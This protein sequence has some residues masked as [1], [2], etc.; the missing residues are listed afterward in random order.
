M[1][2]VLVR[3]DLHPG[4]EPREVI[5]DMVDEWYYANRAKFRSPDGN[6]ETFPMTFRFVLWEDGQDL[7]TDDPTPVPTPSMYSRTSVVEQRDET[8]D[9]EPNI[10]QVNGCGAEI[11]DDSTVCDHCAALACYWCSEHVPEGNGTLVEP[12]GDRVCSDCYARHV[13]RNGGEPDGRQE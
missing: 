2:S 12:S 5:R 4:W 6:G 10:C 11:Y 13:R 8:D 9:A 3:F 1:P 7:E